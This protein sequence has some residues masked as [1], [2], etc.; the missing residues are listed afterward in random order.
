VSKGKN[1]YEFAEAWARRFEGL[2]APYLEKHGFKLPEKI[3]YAFA[4]T[5]K[6]RRGKVRG[7]CWPAATSDDGA[8]EIIVRCD[9]DD[10]KEVAGV[11]FHEYLHACLPPDVRHGAPFKEA[12]LKTGVD[13]EHGLLHAMPGKVLQAEVI[14]PVLEQLGPLPRAKL[15]F[16]TFTPDGQEIVPA[17]KAKKQSTR[18]LKAECKYEGGCGYT[19]RIASSWVKAAEY[20]PPK[21]PRHDVALTVEEKEEENDTQ[22]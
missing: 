10:P 18:M 21:C 22:T 7:E 8:T 12:C 17:D 19:I 11:I 2:I 16:K 1:E 3:R 4:F 9:V 6:G 14:D 5:S 20:G 13:I 15:N